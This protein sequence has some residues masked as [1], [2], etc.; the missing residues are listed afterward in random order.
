MHAPPFLL[1]R[2]E[3][4]APSGRTEGRPIINLDTVVLAHEPSLQPP[5]S[6]LD[7][8]IAVLVLTALAVAHGTFHSIQSHSYLDTSDPFLTS[9]PHHLAATHRLASKRSFLNVVFLKWSW[10]WTSLAFLLLS[11]TS[12]VKRARRW[13]QWAFAT[14]AWFALTSW[15]FGPSLLTRLIIASGGVCGLHIGEALFVP[16]P[17]TYCLTGI[18]V[19]RLTHPELF[20]AVYVGVGTDSND[21]FIPRLRYGHDVSGHVF[22]LT[23]SA[24]FLTDQLRQTRTSAPLYAVGVSGALLSLWVCSLWVTSAYFHAP[25]EKTSGFSAPPPILS[26]HIPQ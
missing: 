24:L 20:P 21:P 17:Q 13:L 1:L 19:S 8:R 15:F 23:L 3:N 25:S 22:L 18:P 6:T 4:S 26:V 5:M 10:S 14:G 12:P 7:S 11:T 9:R 16:I 2:N